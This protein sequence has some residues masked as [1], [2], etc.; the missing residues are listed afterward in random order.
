MDMR[1]FPPKFRNVEDMVNHIFESRGAKCIGKL[2]VYRFVK[3]RIELKMRFNCI[4]DFQ[5]ALCEDPKLIE[6]WF[7]LISNM[8]A[9]YGILD[10]DFYNFD[11]TGFMMGIIYI[12]MVVISAERCGRSKSV[13]L[14]NRK[15]AIAIICGNRENKT[16]PLFLM[17]QG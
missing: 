5:R 4:Y 6:E 12:A 1:G 8:Q 7:R 13:Q 14:G 16:I 3:C 9:K 15:W 2:W 17:V 11:E 10:S